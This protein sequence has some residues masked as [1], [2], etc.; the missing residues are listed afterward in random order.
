[1]ISFALTSCPVNSSPALIHTTSGTGNPVALH[2]N[3]APSP[4]L[5]TTSRMDAIFG[6]TK[7]AEN[8]V[9][10]VCFLFVWGYHHFV[11]VV[12]SKVDLFNLEH[13]SLPLPTVKHENFV[14][15][16]G[17]LTLLTINDS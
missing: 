5:T 1:M 10:F 6:V 8:S 14:R 9:L 2:S 17:I 16:H 3:L 15:S 13:P 11:T 7:T 12:L 4:S